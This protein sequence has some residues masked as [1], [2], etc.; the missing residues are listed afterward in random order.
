MTK[1]LGGYE[2][3]GTGD[4]GNGMLRQRTTNRPNTEEDSLGRSPASSPLELPAAPVITI[5]SRLGTDAERALLCCCRVKGSRSGVI[6]ADITT[7][8]MRAA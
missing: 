8:G 1:H 6:P 7:P 2:L 4:S 3:G 5:V